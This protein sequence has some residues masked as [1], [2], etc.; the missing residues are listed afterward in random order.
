MHHVDVGDALGKHYASEIISMKNVSLLVVCVAICAAA[1]TALGPSSARGI[2]P[3]KK[4]FDNKYVKKDPSTPAEKSFA[5][6]A[7]AAK[8]NV[9]HVGK[10]KKKRNA[11]GDALDELLDKKKDAKNVQK[12]QESL[13]KVAEMHSKKGDD[14]SPTFGDLIKEG[15][16]PGGPVAAAPEDDKPE[17]K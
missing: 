10:D 5:S 15:K 17:E 12:I 6:A 4:E 8:C 7:G 14:S 16:L 11:Y 13:D 9:C 1:M 2:A 3:F